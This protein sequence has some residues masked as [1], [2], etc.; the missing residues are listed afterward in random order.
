MK[1]FWQEYSFFVLLGFILLGVLSVAAYALWDEKLEL[2][3]KKRK[4][5]KKH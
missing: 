3:E 2:A 1:V 4:K 5:K